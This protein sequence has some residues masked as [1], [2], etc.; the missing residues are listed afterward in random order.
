[1]SFERSCVSLA[2][3]VS[4][5]LSYPIPAALTLQYQLFVHCL[6]ACLKGRIPDA[7]DCTEQEESRC[8]RQRPVPANALNRLCETCRHA[9]QGPGAHVICHQMS[10]TL[11]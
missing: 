7:H 5:I 1:M 4:A 10:W 8:L 9:I 3:L 2:S 6:K 11:P